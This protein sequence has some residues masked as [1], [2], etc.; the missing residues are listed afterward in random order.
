MI[1]FAQVETGGEAAMVIVVDAAGTDL[2]TPTGTAGAVDGRG[3]VGL[4]GMIVD[5]EIVE[6]D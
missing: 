4:I 1:L 3:K 5:A 6:G 2:E